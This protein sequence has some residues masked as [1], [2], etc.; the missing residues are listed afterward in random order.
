M[1]EALFKIRNKKKKAG[2]SRWEDEWSLIQNNPERKS[3]VA[4]HLGM[5]QRWR[6]KPN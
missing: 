6:Q 3:E 2:Q 4:K 1:G 5:G